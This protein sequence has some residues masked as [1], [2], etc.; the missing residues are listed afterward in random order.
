MNGSRRGGAIIMSGV[1]PA[2]PG[3]C[4]YAKINAVVQVR[5]AA[6]GHDRSASPIYKDG[7]AGKENTAV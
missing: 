5:E 4:Q 1:N 7:I 6:A 3:Q 2:F